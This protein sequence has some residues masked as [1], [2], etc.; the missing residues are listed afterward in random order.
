MNLISFTKQFPTEEAC[1]EHFKSMR[2]QR[3]IVCPKCDCTNHKWKKNRSQWECKKCG[4]RTT[5]TSGTVMHGTKLPFMYW[6]IS[7]HLLTSTKKSFS[8]SELKR[9]LG[10]KRYQPIWELLHKL[11][12]VM[13]LRDN[14]Y[15]LKGGVELDEGFF[16]IERDELT[17]NQPLKAGRGSQS[18]AKVLVMVESEQTYSKKHR[19]QRKAGHVK[20]VV[21]PNLKKEVITGE[22]INSIHPESELITDGSNSYNEL[23]NHVKSHDSHIVSPK[24]V[25]NLLPWVHIVI[26]NAKRLFLDVYHN[27]KPEFLQSYLNEFCYKFNRRNMDMFDR[28]CYASVSYKTE[29]KHITYAKAG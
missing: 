20:M 26:S 23:H 14:E 5:L 9:Q 22:V 18:K 15:Q 2:E 27:V 28:L 24:E 25:C 1:R 3:G 19:I 21:I 4:Y 6:Y 13:G 10:H 7:M 12:S 17:K 11:R 16:T 29:F 8:A